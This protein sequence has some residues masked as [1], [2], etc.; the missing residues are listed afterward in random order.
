MMSV[1]EGMADPPLMIGPSG[2]QRAVAGI[3]K[4][5]QYACR[6]VGGHYLEIAMD[7]VIP[8]DPEKIYN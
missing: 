1:T 3:R 8:K 6:K 5:I 7:R 4:V 2:E